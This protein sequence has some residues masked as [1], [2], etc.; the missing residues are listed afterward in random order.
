MDQIDVQKRRNMGAWISLEQVET[1]V[2]SAAA[3]RT[4][5]RDQACAGDTRQK[6]CEL[7]LAADE[8]AEHKRKVVARSR[9]S[10]HYD[11]NLT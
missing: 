8:A 10:A 9:F 1:F 11:P 4:G 7:V 6:M 2:A 3:T 5:Q